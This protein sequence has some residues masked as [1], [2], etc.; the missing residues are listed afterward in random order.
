MTF[1]LPSRLGQRDDDVF[2]G[3]RFGHQFDDRRGD[4]HFAEI[5]IIQAVLLG[6]RPHH[7]FAGGIAQPDQGV[8]QLHARL[9]GHLLGFGQLFGADNALA[10]EDFGIIAFAFAAISGSE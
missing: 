2:A 7:V 5:D 4:D 8:G 6:H 3:H 10:D 9:A 1:S